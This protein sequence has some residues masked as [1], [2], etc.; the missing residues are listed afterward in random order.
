MTANNKGAH[1]VLGFTFDVT[2]PLNKKV[3]AGCIRQ[4]VVL[5]KNICMGIGLGGLNVCCLWQLVVLRSWLFEQVWFYDQYW[6]A[7]NDRK[8]INNWNFSCRTLYLGANNKYMKNY[9]ENDVLDKFRWN[10]FIWKD[11][12]S[13]VAFWWI[14]MGKKY[15]LY[16]R[17]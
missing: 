3:A 13:K 6:Y 15:K 8:M 14:Q 17:E 7:T 1:T 2:T 16:K 5:Y 12:V 11:N 10:W 9:N 4:V